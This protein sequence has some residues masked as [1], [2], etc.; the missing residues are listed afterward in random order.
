LRKICDEQGSL[1]LF[2]EVIT[3]FRIAHGGAQEVY[4]IRP[5]LTC[6]GKIIGGGL[7]VGAYGGK[8]KIMRWCLH[9]EG[10]IRQEHFRE[11]PWPWWPAL[12]L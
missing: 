12:R 4:G 1:L 7:P 2:D 8:E 3:G 6:L 9:W 10:S 5:D 11:I